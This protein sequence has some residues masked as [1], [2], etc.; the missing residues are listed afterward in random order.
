M[1]KLAIIFESSPFDRKGLFNAV[2]QRLLHLSR[3]MDC[4]VDVYCIHSWDTAFTRRM[5]HTPEVQKKDQ[6]VIDGIK[7]RLLWYD[8]SIMDHVA[9]KYLHCKPIFFSRFMD[10][11]LGLFEGYD[12]VV[13]HSFTGGLFAMEASKRFGI[14]YFVTWHGSDIHTH[15][16]N[17]PLVLEQTRNVMRGASCNFFVSQALMQASDRICTDVCKDV[18]YNGVSDAFHRY[19]DELR[20]LMRERFQIDADTKVVAFVGSLVSVKNPDM[21]QPLFN[22]IRRC[23]DGLLKFWVIGDGKVR[24]SVEQSL[25]LDS[26]IDV[27]MWGNVPSDRMPDMMNCVDVLVLPSRNEGL[28]LVCAEAVM[29]GAAA[30]GADVGGVSEVVGR[31]NVVPHGPGFIDELSA[32]VVAALEGRE[33]QSLPDIISWE[34]T[35]LKE[36]DYINKVLKDF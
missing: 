1:I 25:M 8:F 29:C 32:K 36:M 15:P 6:V 23:Y 33:K 9:V 4:Q 35:A 16:W 3:N 10:R 22:A 14:P 20:G 13:A 28:P 21:L 30:V 18:L 11:N 27:V 2:H 26:S 5:R 24:Q 34:K 12:A 17:N 31:D 7:Y 19:D